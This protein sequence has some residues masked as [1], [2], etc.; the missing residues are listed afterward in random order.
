MDIPEDANDW[1]AR[2]RPDRDASQGT[3]RQQALSVVCRLRMRGALVVVIG[4]KYGVAV[5]VVAGPLSFSSAFFPK[6]EG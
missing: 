3:R 6:E 1:R 5:V 2:Q 4:F